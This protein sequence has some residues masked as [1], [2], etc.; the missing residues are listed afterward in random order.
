MEL[1]IG[2]YND[3]KLNEI[4]SFLTSSPARAASVGDLP[5]KIIS[6]VELNKKI[7]IEE[8]GTTFLENAL[9]KATKISKETGLITLA[10]DSGLIVPALNG[11]PGIFS[12][13]YAG[14]DATDQENIKKLVS[15]IKGLKREE[16]KAYFQADVVVVKPTGEHIHAEGRV[17]GEIVTTPKGDKGFGY[18]PV[19][20]LPTMRCT[21]AELEIDK[22]TEISHRGAA[23][24]KL[25]PKLKKF[26]GIR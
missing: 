24:I 9:I 5:I 6:L 17:S 15:K 11:E 10:D 8:T 25:A 26:L 16:R 13:R 18:D 20:Y 19:F 23:L 12:S 2:T 7:E 1:L 22:K 3:G 14:D 4:K 21:M